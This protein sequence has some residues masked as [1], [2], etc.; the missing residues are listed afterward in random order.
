MEFNGPACAHALLEGAAAALL[1]AYANDYGAYVFGPVQQRDASIRV[2]DT[3]SAL[4]FTYAAAVTS[5]C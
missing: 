5:S 2:T 1:L 3:D 4:C